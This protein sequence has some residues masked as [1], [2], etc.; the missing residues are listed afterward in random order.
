MGGRKRGCTCLRHEWEGGS[1]GAL[2]SG[3]NERVGARVHSTLHAVVSS[4]AVAA[5]GHVQC[6]VAQHR[7]FSQQCV[8]VFTETI[9][10]AEVVFY[11]NLFTELFQGS[12]QSARCSN[13]AFVVARA[14]GRILS[15]LVHKICLHTH[16]HTRSP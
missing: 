4:L 13:R 10:L 9:S 5:P 16:T 3:V 15:F 12:K 1:E 8:F 14:I 2:A 7:P 11:R 6:I